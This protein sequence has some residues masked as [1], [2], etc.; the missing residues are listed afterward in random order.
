MRQS[1]LTALYQEA[2]L[3]AYKS[4]HNG[5]AETELFQYTHAGVLPLRPRWCGT[6]ESG[7]EPGFSVV[8]AAAVVDAIDTFHRER[9]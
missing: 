7:E 2:W 9:E 6:H 3:R 5:H 8:V 4:R 1:Q